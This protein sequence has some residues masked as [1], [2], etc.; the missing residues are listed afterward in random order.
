VKR[1]IEKKL[2]VKRKETPANT[3]SPELLEG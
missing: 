2:L 1:K 3:D